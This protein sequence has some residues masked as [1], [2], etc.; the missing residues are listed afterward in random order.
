MATPKLE[1][2]ALPGMPLVRP[3]DDLVA[4]IAAGLDAA[5]VSLADNDILVIAQKIISK[6]EDRYVDLQTVTPS[7]RAHE[8]AVTTEKDPRMIEVILSEAAEV[9]RHR[10]GVVV[11]VHRLGFV[12]ANAGIDNSN[13]EQEDGSERVL[14][15]PI[16]SDA[17][18]ARLRERLKTRFGV[19]VGVI[20]NDSVGR[21]WRNGTV[22]IALGAAGVPALL[23]LRGRNDLFERPLQVTQVG[24]ADEVA[25][26]ASILQGQADEGNPVVLVRGLRFDNEEL[27]DAAQLL[28]PVVEDMFR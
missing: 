7:P 5:G 17:S 23:D 20:V 22:G 19:D 9:L 15:L 28:R 4:L 21:A 2:I 24:V 12:M 26:A 16:D 6:S 25:A 1:L 27:G 3:G 8:L 18:C 14:L 11:V 10:P 13:V